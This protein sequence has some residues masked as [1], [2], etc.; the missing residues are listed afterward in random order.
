MAT[1]LRWLALTTSVVLT[2]CGGGGGGGSALGGSSLSLS[3]D[4][5]RFDAFED[6]PTPSPVIVKATYAGDGLLVGYPPDEGFAPW[7]QIVALND[8]NPVEVQLQ[9]M[10]T[11]LPYG[12]YTTTVRFVTGRESTGDVTIR[13][14][15]VT[16]IVAR[17]IQLSQTDLFNSALQGDAIPNAQIVVDKGNAAW[18][19]TSDQTWI[20][21]IKHPSG[22]GG[23]FEV[24]YDTTG[25][26]AGFHYANV[27]V[28]ATDG[29]GQQARLSIR[30]NLSAPAVSVSP[31]T[32]SF[33]ARAGSDSVPAPQAV[34]PT[35]VNGFASPLS[36]NTSYTGSVTDWLTVPSN[37]TA[38]TPFSIAPA[39]TLLAPGH[40]SATVAMGNSLYGQGQVD[41]T[42]DVVVPTLSS[43]PT[44]V[45][46]DANVDAIAADLQGAL[47][48]SDDGAPV[49]WSVLEAP[50]WLEV[51]DASGDSRGATAIRLRVRQ[52]LIS[53]MDNQLYAS[54][55][56]I[57]Y[58]NSVSPPRVLEVPV[59]L[60]LALPEVVGV[61]PYTGIAGQP[62]PH[63]LA[64]SGF[65]SS[66][67]LSVLIDGQ[68]AA[69]VTIETDHL[70][71]FVPPVLE[72][73][74]YEVRINNALGIEQGVGHLT[75][76]DPQASAGQQFIATSRIIGRPVH[77]PGRDA[78]FALVES[79]DPVSVY[80]YSIVRFQRSVLGVWTVSPV[81]TFPSLNS[82]DLAA[83]GKH[84]WIS[85]LDRLYSLDPDDPLANPVEVARVP[86]PSVISYLGI[87]RVRTMT[88]G[89]VLLSPALYS[90][91]F[92]TMLFDPREGTIAPIADPYY[93][94]CH[95]IDVSRDGSRAF[96]YDNCGS[97][98]GV[99]S[100][101]T[102]GDTGFERFYVNEH[103]GDTSVGFNLDGS[104]TATGFKVYDESFNILAGL[105]V[106]FSPTFSPDGR[107]LYNFR[108][109]GDGLPT[110]MSVFDV[111]GVPAAAA[112]PL[113]EEVPLTGAG[114]SPVATVS[115]DSSTLFLGVFV[116]ESQMGL[117]VVP[118]DD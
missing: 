8:G 102:V 51:L 77:D 71:H 105:P 49:S 97:G 19:V 41:V 50:P 98:G 55:V 20:S 27:L 104:R 116:N 84:L 54:A 111:S 67:G 90:S 63:A 85:A 31:T 103:L 93:P 17:N 110:I 39:T 59:T 45:A 35:T 117:L 9:I 99:M 16:Y 7:L 48:L 113:L 58:G 100:A 26:Y 23:D 11:D 83:D 79:G 89:R 107:R 60:N 80:R 94:Y 81:L 3:R 38:G 61:M 74:T 56:R 25:L 44:T 21:F 118:L 52:D 96:K 24:V 34:S 92:P 40:Y 66:E 68:P 6:G 73:G 76:V 72:P 65:A 95:E 36:T 64:G 112:Y 30:L 22:T 4:S 12:T 91:I 2:A 10:S 69:S 106:G 115:A 37:V 29:T 46:F 28:S 32:L 109:Y 78:V 88:D 15:P 43:V 14:V 5:V 1:A 62:L 101:M 87:S 75:V 33:T 70:I 108:Q 82:F 47:A 57:G 18:D 114:W 42:Y 13:D 86:A 53:T